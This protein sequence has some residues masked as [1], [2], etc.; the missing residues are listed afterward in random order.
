MN[1]F[2][3]GLSHYLSQSQIKAIASVSI[4]IGGAGGLGSNLAI[5]LTRSGFQNIEIL[6]A[7]TIEPSNLNRQYYLPKDV[8]C[9]KVDIL[10]KRCQEINPDINMKIHPVRWDLSNASEFFTHCQVV[11]EAFDE[12]ENKRNFV[13]FYQS[14]NE[15]IVS[16]NGMAGFKNNNPL[17]IRRMRNI[18]FVGD[19]TT[20]ASKKT[21][22]LAPRVT[23][24]ASLTAQVILEIA[25]R[26]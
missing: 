22:P 26:D 7:D 3:Q 23:A 12:P 17:T 5:T 15:F 16:G 10:K 6:D 1:V 13:E 14:R 21:P 2:K 11:V 19:Q 24:C 9:L 18:T 20:R 4:G 8:G 25:L